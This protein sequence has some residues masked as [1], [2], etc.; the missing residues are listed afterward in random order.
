M[1]LGEKQPKLVSEEM[2]QKAYGT[3]QG[4]RTLSAA[5]E[6]QPKGLDDA[7]LR[8]DSLPPEV[9]NIIQSY[10]EKIS[11]LTKGSQSAALLFD[12]FFGE[13]HALLKDSHMR[14]IARIRNEHSVEIIKLR[15]TLDSRLRSA[16]FGKPSS[17]AVAANRSK[18]N[19]QAFK[20]NE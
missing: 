17:A 3:A 1:A 15:K 18:E 13:M 6:D 2:Q 12:D 20:G 10:R 8:D 14:E 7:Y 11:K 5:G 16:S 19:F 9:F 4:G